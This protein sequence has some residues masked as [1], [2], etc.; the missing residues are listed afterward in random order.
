MANSKRIWNKEELTFAYYVSKYGTLNGLNMD[1]EE[2][3]NYI[4]GDTTERSFDMQVANFNYILG[5]IDSY[6]LDATSKLQGEIVEE[7]KNKTVT[8]VR[9]ILIN[10]AESVD[11]KARERK[12]K[13]KNKTANEKV[14]E[15]NA[16]SQ[17]NFEA[18]LAMYAQMGRRLTPVKK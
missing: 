13:A 17:G 9:D 1:K 7:L 3:V 18:K 6:Q 10:Y 16:I 4:I 14:A 11:D 15:L 2:I 5:H 8:Q 12:V